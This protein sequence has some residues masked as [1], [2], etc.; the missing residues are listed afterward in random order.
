M[1]VGV[2]ADV[3]ENCLARR[4]LKMLPAPPKE[5]FDRPNF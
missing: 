2:E 3:T 5:C 1:N 4:P